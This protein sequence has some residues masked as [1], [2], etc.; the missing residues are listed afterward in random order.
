MK[1]SGEVLP[2]LKNI[3][4]SFLLRFDTQEENQL[5][6]VFYPWND[7]FLGM[8]KKYFH[9]YFPVILI[10]LTKCSLYCL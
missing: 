1:T 9:K 7:A 5:T 4:A 8:E 2:D 3:T 6:S 10:D